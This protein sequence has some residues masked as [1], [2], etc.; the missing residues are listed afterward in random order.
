MKE[1]K[2]IIYREGLLGSLLLG[3]SKVDPERF[4]DFLNNHARQGWRVITMEREM[5]RELLIFRREAFMVIMERE[6]P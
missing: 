5:R 4:S 2:V 6:Q 1:Y 3:Q